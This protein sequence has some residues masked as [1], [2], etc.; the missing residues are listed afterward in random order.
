MQPFSEIDVFYK[1]IHS[2]D[3]HRLQECSLTWKFLKQGSRIRAK[4]WLETEQSLYYWKQLFNSI[5]VPSVYTRLF[6]WFEPASYSRKSLSCSINFL[7]LSIF[8]FIAYF[9]RLRVGTQAC[10]LC[11]GSIIIFLWAFGYK[12]LVKSNKPVVVNLTAKCGVRI[13]KNLVYL[14]VSLFCE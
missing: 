2:S 6:K 3:V 4:F 7:K 5:S 1:L 9:G 8:V 12:S 14:A 10:K 13:T 11:W